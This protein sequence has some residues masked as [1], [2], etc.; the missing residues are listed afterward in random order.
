M[1]IYDLTKVNMK[2]KK[3][4][5]KARLGYILTAKKFCSRPKQS[6]LKNSILKLLNMPYLLVILMM[7]KDF[8]ILR[9]RTNGGLSSRL[10]I[11]RRQSYVNNHIKSVG[12]G[13]LD[14]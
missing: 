3:D 9:N 12:N 1:I 5:C 7:L 14:K 8:F 13:H 2:P 10:E 11:K 6:E 4:W